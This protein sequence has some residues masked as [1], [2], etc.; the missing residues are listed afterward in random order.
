MAEEER[1]V[2]D[3]NSVL[4]EGSVIQVHANTGDYRQFLLFKLATVMAFTCAVWLNHF[5]V[6]GVILVTVSAFVEF[7]FCK[8]RDGL[9]YVGMRWCQEVSDQGV[10]RWIFYSRKDPYVPTASD[11]RVFW[12]GLFVS[13]V[14]W[15][16]LVAWSL[17]AFGWFFSTLALFVL[18]LEGVNVS[19]FLQCQR[20]ASKHIEDMTRMVLGI[21]KEFDS[22]NL[23]PELEIEV[24]APLIESENLPKDDP[25]QLVLPVHIKTGEPS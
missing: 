22:D 8:N 20:S 6:V 19:A 11:T 3:D 21:G 23:E 15:S 13:L 7:W 24:E 1:R 14:I 25:P 17:L 18:L 16:G 5:P 12:S 2:H 10:P 4:I 9:E